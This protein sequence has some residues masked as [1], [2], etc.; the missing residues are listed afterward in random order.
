MY[1]V[2]CFVP[3]NAD[4]DCVYW[5]CLCT[6]KDEA[7]R[8]V[9]M[10]KD[11]GWPSQIVDQYTGAV[12]SDWTIN[13][14]LKPPKEPPKMSSLISWTN[15]TWNP[16]TGCNKVSPGCANC[17]AERKAATRLKHVAAYQGT[18][19]A[20]GRWS[21]QFNFLGA[22]LS[23]PRKHRQPARVF[24]NSMSDL[25]GDISFEEIATVFG[26][27]ALA[28]WHEYQI[29]TKRPASALAFF[30]WLSSDDA[31]LQDDDEQW[32]KDRR[33]LLPWIP[34][35]EALRCIGYAR[36]HGL[37]FG[38]AFSAF[39]R[40]MA[41]VP[42]QAEDHARRFA[43]LWPLHCVWLGVSVE[44]AAYVNR[45]EVLRELPAALRWVSFEPLLGHIEP[46]LIDWSVLDWIVV[47]GESGKK[48]RPMHPSWL[49][50]L[51]LAAKDHR[52]PRHFKQ[53]GAFVQEGH[54]ATQPPKRPEAR[55]VCA[56]GRQF[57]QWHAYNACDPKPP[58][59]T[60]MLRMPTNKSG[61]LWMGRSIQE[62]PR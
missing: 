31:E 53:W 29:L 27:M 10:L 45:I 55:I 60:I 47:G 61:A 16:V 48:A 14:E 36:R 34:S 43:L 32:S 58:R 22:R 35:K 3:S 26:A 20:A 62:Y 38:R 6:R 33:S 40:W 57:K 5:S 4:G 56:D 46:H 21:G 1:L 50:E 51:L 37:D 44:S 28:P 25:F 17:Y 24:V 11:M 9:K 7:R 19:T 23:W 41:D 2:E 13:V 59:P 42:L 12:E 52:V 15:E 30:D 49:H 8:V 54:A 39:E 18:T